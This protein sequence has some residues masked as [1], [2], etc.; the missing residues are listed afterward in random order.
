MPDQWARDNDKRNSFSEMG[1]SGWAEDVPATSQAMGR[2]LADGDKNTTTS[3]SQPAL[4]GAGDEKSLACACLAM[5]YVDIVRDLLHEV[6]VPNAIGW[7]KL[8]T[9]IG[10]FHYI[11][12]LL[13]YV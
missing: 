5:P 9:L 3:A 2:Q 13:L 6:M 1:A 4:N 12:C 11:Y 8:K 7:R 10:G